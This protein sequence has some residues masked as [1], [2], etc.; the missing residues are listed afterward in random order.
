[1]IF[2]QHEAPVISSDYIRTGAQ[3]SATTKAISQ[4]SLLSHAINALIKEIDPVQYEA[5]R[6]LRKKCLAQYPYLKALSSLDPL[7][8]EG[9]AIQ[10]NR[11][12]PLHP[13]RQDP[14]KSWATMITFGKFT[15]GGDLRIPRLNLDMRYLPRD[16]VIVRG[17][18]LPHEVKAWGPGQRLS[19]AHFTHESL[20]R[21]YGMECP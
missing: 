4:V 7:V 1:M 9:R 20:W 3:F 5:L 10:F 17:R 16:V 6:T 13:D 21:S 18:L 19:I 2:L 8:M 12:T 15:A 11:Q 14:R